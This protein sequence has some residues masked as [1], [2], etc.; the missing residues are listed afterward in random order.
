MYIEGYKMKEY[1]IYIYICIPYSV[2]VHRVSQI[3]SAELEVDMDIVSVTRG[4]TCRVYRATVV[5]RFPR[6]IHLHGT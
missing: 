2:D 5:S 6:A 3:Q 4:G 1:C